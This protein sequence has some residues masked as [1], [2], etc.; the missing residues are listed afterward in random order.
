MIEIQIVPSDIRRNV[1]YVFFDRRRVVVAICVLAGVLAAVIGSMAAAPTVIRRVYRDTYAK[2][3]RVERDIQRERLREN[4]LQMTSLE[5]SLEEQRLRVEKL[6]T[7]YGLEQ[8]LGQGGFSFPLHGS[9]DAAEVQL[10]DATQR[11][12]ALRHAMKRLQDQIELLAEYEKANADLVRH[13]PSILPLPPDQFVLTSPFGMRISPFTRA[14]DFHKGLDLSAP[15]GT[16]IYAAADGVVS[17]AGRYPLRDS[18]QWWRFGNV[19]VINHSNR[20]VTIYGHCDTV[21]VH[22]GQ[23]VRQGEIVATVGSTGWSTNSH[24]HY[25]VRSDL[26]H[27]GTYVPIDP[28]IYILNYQWSNEANL[29]A[30]ARATR[31]YANFD[32]LPPVF[33]GKGK[34]KSRGRRRV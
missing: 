31:D 14:A 7:V 10:G 26:E 21:K 1:R 25:E 5:R 6:V 8:N 9:G 18:V 3:M 4:V 19:V 2:S 11:E 16:A 29:L 30:R 20:F 17:F 22:R 24:L 27:P 23:Q 13:T 32:P 12:N 34:V 28:R 33:L 15:T